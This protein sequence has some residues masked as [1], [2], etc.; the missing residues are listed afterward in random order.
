MCDS[1]TIYIVSTSGVDT[2][3]WFLDCVY[4]EKK[5]SVIL[6]SRK[7]IFLFIFHSCSSGFGYHWVLGSGKNGGYCPG[8]QIA[9][10]RPV[11]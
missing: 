11:P 7:T 5:L 1:F 8:Q 9:V 3:P 10:E 4:G 6:R 2:S